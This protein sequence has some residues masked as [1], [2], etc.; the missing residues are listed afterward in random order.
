M[1]LLTEA[2]LVRALTIEDNESR[3]DI[4]TKDHGHFK[5]ETCG[6]IYNFSVDMES[7]APG[8]LDHFMIRDRDVYFKGVCERCLSNIEKTE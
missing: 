3:Y 6:E 7:L 5:C 1:K 8:G 4:M 2:G